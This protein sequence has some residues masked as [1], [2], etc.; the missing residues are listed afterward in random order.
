M[1]KLKLIVG[2]MG[3]GVA[4]FAQEPL[5]HPKKTFLASDGKLYIQKELP[6]YIWM[7]TSTNGESEKYRLESEVTYKYSN[8]MYFDT[9]GYNTVRSPWAVDTSTRVVVYPKR[10]IIFE[11]YA[12]SESP[13]TKVDFGEGVLYEE[14]G[15]LHLGSGT[16][17]T[18]TAEDKL[19]GV[20]NILFSING[21]AYQPYR[22]PIP[23]N[24]EKEYT[25]KYYSVDNVGNVEPVH[26]QILI[27]D[28]TPPVSALEIDKDRYENII[29]GRSKI[30][31]RSE[32]K[33]TGT[34]SILYSIDSGNEIEY[35]IP[36]LA[37][38][39]TQDEHTIAFYAVDK[40]GNEEEIQTFTFY[41]DK[42]PPTIIE[43]II[44]K[45]FFTGGKEFSSGKTRLKLTSF[46]NKAGVKEVRYSVNEGEYELYDKPV[47]L[48]QASGVLRILSYAV[49]NVNNRSN[50]QTANEKT[51]IPY[52]D[53]TGPQLS[54]TFRG[55]QF[56]TR[57]TIFINNKTLV[58]LTGIDKESGINRIE[59]SLN[60]SDPSDY[61]EPFNVENEGYSAVDYTGFDNVDNTSS[62]SFGFKVDNT[63]PKISHTFGAS[64]INRIN[65]LDVYPAHV[66]L[67]VAATDAVVGFKKM[68]Y[69][70]NNG[71]AKELTGMMKALPKG[72]NQLVITAYDHL[73]NTQNY[74]LQ[75]IIE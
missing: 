54:Q 62:D 3:I 58:Q 11:V 1:F 55:P 51:S 7:S 32:D 2:L 14:S 19:S 59:Y 15:K 24:E 17:I 10:D 45:S 50:S 9:E 40:V 75:F 12:D 57:D 53:L 44:G 42:T 49:D 38:N 60:G 25:L 30:L 18:L 74:E 67:F 56:K 66:V 28:R 22:E 71:P 47:F 64:S 72:T 52:I 41:V 26:E 73:G 70:L 4:M 31:L 63:G 5:H 34:K 39:F 8:P 27:F 46:D 37:T 48:T 13:V 16:L 36:I 68:D 65:G 29:S 61:S 6:V 21:A 33:G 43:E 23:I 35:R 69:T 20:E